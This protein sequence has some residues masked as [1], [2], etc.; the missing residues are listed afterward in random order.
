M[1][2][3]F[4]DGQPATA[5]D[6]AHQA[7]VNY[8][9]YTSFAVTDGGV[10]GLDRHLARL[11]EA[12]VE[13]FG[14]VVPEDQARAWMRQALGNRRDAW[15]R[16]SLFAPQIGV[17]IPDWTGRP[18]MMVGVF[19]PVAPLSATPVRL[20]PQTYGRETPHLKHAATFGLIRARR[21][22]RAAG[23]DDAL[24]VCADGRIAEASV[25]NIGFLSGARII[26][27]EAP[28]LSGVSQALISDALE[29]ETRPVTLADLP[30]FDGAFLTTSATPACAVAAIGDH[31]FVTT[32]DRIA[33]VIA[34]WTA[35]PLQ[36]F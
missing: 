12:A 19:D 7:L 22:A 35:A 21:S 29:T 2:A 15:M 30:G 25:S 3:L 4:I 13:L 18:R 16:V 17:R 8:G 14:E 1:T 32:A 27:P 20:K 5:D 26:W 6:L 23:F 11:R 24:F 33:P 10:R 36:S 34:A 9:A 28:M 31:V